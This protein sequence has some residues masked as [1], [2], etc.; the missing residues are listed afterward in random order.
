MMLTLLNTTVCCTILNE[1]VKRV[2][3]CCSTWEQ[4]KDFSKYLSIILCNGKE[5]HMIRPLLGFGKTCATFPFD[6]SIS[7]AFELRKSFA[8]MGAYFSAGAIDPLSPSVII[9][10]LLAGF[11]PFCCVLVGRTCLNITPVHLWWSIPQFLWPACVIMHWHDEEK[12]DCD[13]YWGLKSS[14]F[15]EAIVT[16][17]WTRGKFS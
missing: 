11:H 17:L 12:F 2:L 7:W 16:Q 3:H 8:V 10:N 14:Q 15:T 9:Q 5:Y 4:K 6:M 1:L 13:H